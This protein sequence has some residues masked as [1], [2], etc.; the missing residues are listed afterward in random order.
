[1]VDFLTRPFQ[2]MSKNALKTPDIKIIMNVCT[3]LNKVSGSQGPKILLFEFFSQF[4]LLLESI[5]IR[6]EPNNYSI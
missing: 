3:P 4:L 2:K 6:N 5:F 1:M